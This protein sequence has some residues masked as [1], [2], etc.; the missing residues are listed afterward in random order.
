MLHKDPDL[1]SSSEKTLANF[2]NLPYELVEH[3]FKKLTKDFYYDHLYSFSHFHQLRLISHEW[4][5]DSDRYRW[6]QFRRHV[7]KIQDSSSPIDISKRWFEIFNFYIEA[8][9]ELSLKQEVY[10]FLLVLLSKNRFGALYYHNPPSYYNIPS[11]L[12]PGFPEQSIALV[13]E[14]AR[15]ILQSRL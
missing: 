3:I 8:E 4:K 2:A 7:N 14:N 13:N 1:E 6:D 9:H 11:R 5:Q 10:E 12:K 15:F